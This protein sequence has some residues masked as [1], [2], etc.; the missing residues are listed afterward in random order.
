MIRNTDNV[1]KMYSKD[2]KTEAVFTKTGMK[3][4]FSLR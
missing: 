2:I 1:N 3:C 4:Y